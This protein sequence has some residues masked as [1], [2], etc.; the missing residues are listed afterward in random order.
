MDKRKAI[1]EIV[2]L[3]LLIN[4]FSD[5]SKELTGNLPTVF[6]EYS[7][8]VS[9]L[10]VRIHSKGWEEDTLPDI[11]FELY[12]DKKYSQEELEKCRRKLI[13]IR[14]FMRGKEYV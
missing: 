12:V 14:G 5:R 4:G 6:L 7:G 3:A 10:M 1:L 13:E 11:V 9:L 2:D 8:H